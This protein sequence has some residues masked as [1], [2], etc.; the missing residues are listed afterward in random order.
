M[1]KREIN[2]QTIYDGCRNN[3][4]LYLSYFFMTK[5]READ[6]FP[7]RC[8]LYT[9]RTSYIGGKMM[10]LTLQTTL[11]HAPGQ[12]SVHMFASGEVVRAGE[13]SALPDS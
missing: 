9:E 12:D 2:E 6:P 11:V 10:D 13:R 8:H 4:G 3:C 1:L 5:Q 7:P